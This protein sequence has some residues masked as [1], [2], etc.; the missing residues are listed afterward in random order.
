MSRVLSNNSSTFR[1][2][3]KLPIMPSDE[4]LHKIP[5][6][7]MPRAELI[8]N[9]LMFEIPEGFKKALELGFFLI[10]IPK[11]FDLSSGDNFVRNFFKEKDGCDDLDKY[12]GFKRLDL[13]QPYQGYFDREFDQWENFYIESF[14]WKKYLTTELNKLGNQ[15]TELGIFILKSV[16]NHLEIS[17]DIWNITTG[18]LTK[19]AGHHMLAFNHFRSDKLVRGTKFHRDSG[20]ITILRSWQPGLVA[21]INN[22][23]YA[24]NPVEGYFIV[25]FGSS[26]E[27][28]TQRL[29]TPAR[30]NIHGVVKTIRNNN[31][32]ERFSYVVFLDSNLAGDIYQLDEQKKPL[33]IQTVADFAIQEVN[34][35]YDDNN[36]EL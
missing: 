34:R 8:K 7:N 18:G 15:M 3:V 21:L 2:E 19:K 6:I 32:E 5:S 12:R 10:K 4:D 17:K 24:I 36:L 31:Q 23:L 20:W 30:S 27:V 11:N 33:F 1:E 28:L 16:L 26:I 35:T 25:N 9:H 14:Y 29:E 22:N 13:K